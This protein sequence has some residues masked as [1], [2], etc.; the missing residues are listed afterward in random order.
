MPRYSGFGPA[1]Q[2]KGL[3]GHQLMDGIEHGLVVVGVHKS[4]LPT[5]AALQHVVHLPGHDQ[6]G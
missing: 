1:G 3:F 2:G 4:G 5:V 6:A